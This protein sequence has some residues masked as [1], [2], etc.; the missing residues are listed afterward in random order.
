MRLALPS[1]V[2]ALVVVT[3]WFAWPRADVEAP[4]APALTTEPAAA[5][6]AST[7]ATATPEREQAV[8]ADD[9]TPA[10]AAV[11]TFLDGVPVPS[12]VRD[13]R[14]SPPTDW[15]EATP[16]HA[17]PVAGD[18]FAVV[19]R[20]CQIVLLDRSE[21]P[22]RGERRID[23]TR[24]PVLDVRL[25]NVPRGLRDRLRLL[26]Q[27]DYGQLER[28]ENVASLMVGCGPF[29]LAEDRVLVPLALPKPGRLD[30]HAVSRHSTHSYPT[31]KVPFEPVSQVIEI[32]LG[33]LAPACSLADLSLTLR[34][35]YAHPDGEMDLSLVDDAGST[36]MY[37]RRVRGGARQLEYRFRDLPPARVQP[38]LQQRAGAAS[39]PIP[40][41]PIELRVGDV[42]ATRDVVAE[43]SLHVV[44]SG[45]EGLAEDGVS[46]LLRMESGDVLVANWPRGNDTRFERLAATTLYAQ[47]VAYDG[48]RCSPIV[49]IEI[50]SAQSHELNLQLVP[51]AKVEVAAS[52]FGADVRC[53]DVHLLGQLACRV[54][55]LYGRHTTFWLPLGEARVQWSGGART[56]R[57][58]PGVLNRWP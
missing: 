53:L 49:R 58:D 30:V 2:I 19:A 35:P 4:D 39:P 13:V 43:S 22:P 55:L 8:A 50:G 42:E 54:A 34:F 57:V 26:L 25:V 23:M 9:T 7:T 18:R 46:V 15:N 29:D 47:A 40:L 24:A 28:G 12:L 32:D 44:L 27:L 6:V 20:D 56:L 16:R 14:L 10:A 21:L 52:A 31:P 5:P 48:R 41:A 1:L 51:A 37:Q 3:A 11:C 45:R 33:V 38:I 36:M 17:V